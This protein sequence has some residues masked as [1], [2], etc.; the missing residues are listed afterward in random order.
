MKKDFENKAVKPKENKKVENKFEAR[1]SFE[2]GSKKVM[3]I[4]ATSKT[5]VRKQILSEVDGKYGLSIEE[6]K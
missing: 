3:T 4:E 5:E 1:L 6:I 2:D